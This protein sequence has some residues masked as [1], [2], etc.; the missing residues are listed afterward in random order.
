MS[1]A[2]WLRLPNSVSAS[3]VKR[4]TERQPLRTRP[5]LEQLEDRMLL[6]GASNNF[7]PNLNNP[8]ATFNTQQIG[9]T[10]PNN[11][12]RENP[13]A[14]TQIVN[15]M[16]S[17]LLN[18]VAI[19]AQANLLTQGQVYDQFRA[20]GVN[21]QGQA[22]LG[23]ANGNEGLQLQYLLT[24]MG[25][26]SGVMPNAPWMPAAYN[27]GLANHQFNYSAQSDMGFQSAPPWTHRF[28]P[29][30]QDGQQLDQ[31]EGTHFLELQLKHQ[32][33]QDHDQQGWEGKDENQDDQNRANPAPAQ[34]Q[35][36]TDEAEAELGRGDPVIE[37]ALFTEPVQALSATRMVDRLAQTKVSPLSRAR[38]SLS[39]N[40][41]SVNGPASEDRALLSPLVISAVA[42]AQI[43]ALVA[44]LPGVSPPASSGE[45]NMGPA[46]SE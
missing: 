41:D 36:V 38:H 2:S 1:F 6:N 19:G 31:E 4:S 24:A 15:G 9:L 18:G 5:R 42:P 32:S 45:A 21:S 34:K 3:A 13:L 10:L 11:F 25:F 27:L 22:G 17:P 20:F 26:G 28:T 46:P 33:S 30:A 23:N 7:T 40:E 8:S 44:G 43:A 14:A 37:N 16:Q 29:T 12:Q 39:G 35:F